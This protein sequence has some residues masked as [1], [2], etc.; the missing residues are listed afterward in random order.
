MRSA[1]VV[2]AL[3]AIALWIGGNA[4]AAEPKYGKVD[5]FEPGKKY[6]CVP[7]ADHKSWNCTEIAPGKPGE[8]AGGGTPT[9]ETTPLAP[10]A[11]ARTPEPIPAAPAAAPAQQSRPKGSAL[12]SYLRATGS[13]GAAASAPPAESP[14]PAAAVP[15]PEQVTPT[16]PAPVP[17]AAPPIAG[18]PPATPSPRVETAPP[19]PK[20]S[21]APPP[22]S[23]PLAAPAAAPSPVAPV[24][25]TAAP[26]A[27]APEATRP[28]PVAPAKPT[29]RTKPTESGATTTE[30]A[31]ATPAPATQEPAAA[32][33]APEMPAPA[34][35]APAPEPIRAPEPAPAPKPAHTEPP[36]P[37]PAAVAAPAHT[38]STPTGARGNREFLALPASGYVIELA[39]ST[40]PAELAA[41]HASLQLTH[42][43]LYEL[44]LRR[45]N[46]DW[47][48]LVWASFDSVDAAR[49]ARS[50]LPAD[51]AINA[52]WPRRIGALQAEAR[53]VSSNQ[54]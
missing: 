7:T 36:S 19:A 6:T 20:M 1:E 29:A 11:A 51:A 34:S 45:D 54:D 31:A 8:K 28:E 14:A 23:R 30:T 52:G 38:Q 39:H 50:E 32:A 3:V 9:V 5:T 13:P 10:P 40:N 33:P 25:R 16:A 49:A 22:P 35:T 17:A 12:P 47:W 21:E 2:R 44:H 24:T 42:G 4:Q 41:L 37:P 43:E 53:R 18:P 15:A 46:G 27:A 26:P 48:L